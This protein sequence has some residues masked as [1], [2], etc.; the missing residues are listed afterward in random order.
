MKRPTILLEDGVEVLFR[1]RRKD[2]T[3]QALVV[4]VRDDGMALFSIAG[5]LEKEPARI[6]ITSHPETAP[7]IAKLAGGFKQS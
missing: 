4:S 7:T 1:Y 3:Q 2:G 6:V 5:T